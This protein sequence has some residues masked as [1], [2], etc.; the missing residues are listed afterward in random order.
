[1]SEPTLLDVVYLAGLFEGE[2]YVGIS[3]K[4]RKSITTGK[5]NQLALG[6]VIRMGDRE[7][8]DMGQGHFGG[9]IYCVNTDRLENWRDMFQWNLCSQQAATFLAAIRPHLRTAK[10]QTR[11]D[12]ALAFQA[13]KVGPGGFGRYTPEAYTVRQQEFYDAM[14][15]LNQK[16][17]VRL[18][19][20]ERR[21]L[22]KSVK[23]TE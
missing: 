18:N 19:N 10:Y 5:K 9:R 13:Q 3:R 15:Q 1:M 17:R 20:D 11:V 22:V 12:L 21:A 23:E 8:L 2:G 14:R 6:T 16:G 4:G 7:P